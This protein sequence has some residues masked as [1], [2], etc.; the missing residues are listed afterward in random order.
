MEDLAELDISSKKKTSKDDF[1]VLLRTG[2]TLEAKARP[3]ESLSE[4]KMSRDPE[5]A[6]QLNDLFRADAL[7]ENQMLKGKIQI[8]L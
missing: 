8:Q 7:A 2:Q 6:K 1:E 3:S 4:K 5:V